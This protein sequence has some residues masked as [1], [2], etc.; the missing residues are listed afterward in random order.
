MKNWWSS[1]GVFLQVAQKRDG[2]EQL[3]GAQA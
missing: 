3:I 2:A 1:F